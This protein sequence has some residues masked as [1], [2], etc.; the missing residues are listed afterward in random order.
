MTM[1]A[2]PEPGLP[3]WQRS[4][5]PAM[6][7]ADHADRGQAGASKLPRSLRDWLV[8]IVMFVFALGVGAGDAWSVHGSSPTWLWI[9]DIGLAVVSL[10]ALWV[11]RRH[12]F[13]VGIGVIAASCVSS[14]SGGA[15]IVALFTVAV[16]CPSRRTLQAL[17]L[18]LA[19][20]VI[21]PGIYPNHGGTHGY[22][23][24]SLVFGVLASIVAVAFGAFVRAR[25]DLVI[26]LHE[27]NRQLQADQQR[28][29]AE[30]Q[31]A[32]RNRIAREMHDVLAHRISLLS[33][34]AG[35]L[36]F[37]PEATPEE[38]ARA[39]RVIRE[40]ARAAQEELREVIGVL[41]ADPEAGPVVEPPQ[42]TLDDLQDLV[43]ESRRAG[44]DVRLAVA[45]A[46]HAL[47]PTLG[48]TVYRL[49]QEALTNARKHAPDQ[50]V[51]IVVAGGERAG[52]R[53][54]ATN[55]PVVGRAVGHGPGDQIGSG[56]GLVGLRERV[57][58]V[59]GTLEW[60]PLPGGGFRLS[61]TLPWKEERSA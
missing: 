36:E 37:N 59:G 11:R 38:I 8:D 1:S 31:R 34:H 12:P 18:A 24:T 28:R 49:V 32:E 51:A 50:P 57:A 25:R 17:G 26:S 14:A 10:G 30:A 47:P 58:L 13:G 4:L 60:G 42:P 9:V 44:M 29:V 35:A 46:P 52:V 20:S 48:R 54:S 6:L 55:Q 21:E 53:V 39:A 27:R 16:Y 45:L 19:T 15:A 7:G 22:D 43:Q 40:S 23:V 2:A 61:A 3:R 5:L 56:T 41:R 33:V